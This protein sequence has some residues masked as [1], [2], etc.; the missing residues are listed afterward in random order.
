MEFTDFKNSWKPGRYLPVLAAEE[1]FFIRL[2]L[3]VAIYNI[4]IYIV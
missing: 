4:P 3:I 1:T 2:F